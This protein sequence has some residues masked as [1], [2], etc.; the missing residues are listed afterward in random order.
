MS[1]KSTEVILD[2]RHLASI[3]AIS[4]LS[5][6]SKWKILDRPWPWRAHQSLLFEP[7]LNFH[8]M[9]R[10]IMGTHSII[11]HLCLC[12]I[13]DCKDCCTSQ[14][15]WR[16]QTQRLACGCNLTPL[17]WLF[18]SQ[19]IS[20]IQKCIQMTS[21]PLQT[22]SLKELHFHLYSLLSDIKIPSR[23]EVLDG[24][25]I[26]DMKLPLQQCP[27]LIDTNLQLPPSD[28]GQC[29][30]RLSLSSMYTHRLAASCF[31]S[32]AHFICL[33]IIPNFLSRQ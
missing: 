6:I 28:R 24:W 29:Y 30:H 2:P 33:W 10:E 17:L 21:D 1:V 15:G 12:I 14:S 8:A 4:K 26:R 16:F 3:S 19:C 23:A 11:N 31:Q 20:V 9:L 7:E 32:W 22:C 25:H 18:T 13:C 27:Y 5:V